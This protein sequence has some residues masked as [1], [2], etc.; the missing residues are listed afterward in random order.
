MY[1]TVYMVTD[2]YNCMRI[3][4]RRFTPLTVPYILL[5]LLLCLNR[6]F[7]TNYV[8][9]NIRNYVHKIRLISLPK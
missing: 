3:L 5:N 4:L 2:I 7:Q 9:I 8:F 6:Y 1:V